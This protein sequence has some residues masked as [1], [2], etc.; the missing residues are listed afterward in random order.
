MNEHESTR[1]RSTQRKLMGFYP[2]GASIS[3]GFHGANF[4]LLF[5]EPGGPRVARSVAGME[6]ARDLF[7]GVI[8][9]SNGEIPVTHVPVQ[10]GE[11]MAG[12]GGKNK[13]MLFGFSNSEKRC[14]RMN[15]VPDDT[16]RMFDSIL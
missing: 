15:R 14:V 11:M 10:A 16:V 3:D 8:G 4:S 1:I 12:E 7:A 2:F 9:S 6:I 5:V 13:G